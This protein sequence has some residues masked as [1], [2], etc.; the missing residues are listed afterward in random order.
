MLYAGS[1]RFSWRARAAAIRWAADTGFR[2]RGHVAGDDDNAATVRRR[3]LGAGWRP[4]ESYWA[5]S[6]A[7]GG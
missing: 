4:A 5:V 6:A 7:G 2:L 3:L 1:G